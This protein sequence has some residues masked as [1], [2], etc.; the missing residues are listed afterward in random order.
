MTR[1]I[2]KRRL[3]T[4]DIFVT[5]IGFGAMQFSGGK[6]FF[7]YFLAAIPPETMNETLQTAITNGMNWIDTAEIY[8][9]GASELAV[10]QALTA[11]GITPDDIVIT[12]KWFPLFKRA[13]SIKKS[14]EKSTNRL[15]PYPVDLYLIHNRSSISSI[16]AQMDVMADLVD[17]GQIRAVGVSNFSADRMIAAHEALSDR[18]IPLAA[19]QMKFSLL[20]RRIE[21]NGVLDTAREL[22][23]TIIAY[24]PL[25]QGILTGKIHSTPEVLDD[26]PRFRRRMLRSKMNKSQS[27]VEAIESIAH[28]HD[29]TA[30]QVSLSWATNIHD[31]TIVAIPGASKPIQAEQNA[32]SM[33][34]SLSSEQMETLS[35]LSQEV[36]G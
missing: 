12:T 8:G 7:K 6:G 11:A 5:P 28:E 10:S 30:A 9:S 29:A 33:Q 20:H 34:L 16:R 19:N 24:T 31:E 32:R 4:T 3:G 2:E 36:I 21:H 26:M 25:G 13:K 22:G 35:T 1:E 18:G 27:L 14:A 23:V 15:N 17:S